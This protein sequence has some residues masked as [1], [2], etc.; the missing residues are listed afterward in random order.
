MRDVRKTVGMV[1]QDPDDQLFM[2]TVD[3]DVAFGPLNLGLPAD[4]VEA[5]V[6]RRSTG[7]GPRRCGTGRPTASPAARSASVAIATVLAM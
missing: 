4:E 5:R 7:W 2:P 3:E 6:A 1:F